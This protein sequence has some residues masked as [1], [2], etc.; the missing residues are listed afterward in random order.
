MV[1][2]TRGA[3]GRLIMPII[4]VDVFTEKIKDIEF[5]DLVHALNG[6]IIRKSD[7]AGTK[8]QAWQEILRTL[9]NRS[10]ISIADF[11]EV[12][13]RTAQSI[14]SDDVL[15]HFGE[16]RNPEGHYADKV[17]FSTSG[18]DADL[19]ASVYEAREVWKRAK[20]MTPMQIANMQLDA[21]D[22]LPKAEP[23]KPSGVTWENKKR[24]FPKARN[25]L[26][27]YSSVNS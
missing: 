21:V 20:K 15:R 25:R 10:T 27:Y 14:L 26:F 8:P 24:R 1:G 2:I 11:L 5:K 12:V 3:D 17:L 6:R 4:T 18:N 13:K 16:E 7:S 23:R 22:P 9:E 19:L